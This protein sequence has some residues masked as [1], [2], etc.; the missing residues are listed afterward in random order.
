MNIKKQTTRLKR[1]KVDTVSKRDHIYTGFGFKV[2]L[3]NA[4]MVEING[5][6]MLDIDYNKLADALFES[7]SEKS[8]RLTG[9]EVKFIRHH[10][11]LTLEKFSKRF[12]VSHPAV[13][14]WEKQGDKSTN[15]TWAIEKDIRLFILEIS[16]AKASQY[17]TLYQNLKK[18]PAE[19]KAP[20][21]TRI[22]VQEYLAV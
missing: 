8:T 13:I 4:P 20:R 19:S 16:K 7:I 9:A 1:T 17:K 5:E 10:A 14:K 18:V 15:M 3:M 2:K 12:D 6:L 22:D 21:L 11:G